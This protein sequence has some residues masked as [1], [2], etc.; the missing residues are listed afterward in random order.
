MRQ[1][2]ACLG[3]CLAKGDVVALSGPLG[4]GKTT[5]VQGLAQGLGVPAERHVSSPTFALVNQ[6]P[7]RIDLV[8]VD[9]Y[10]IASPAELPELGLE[11]AYDQAA[12]A[13]EWA[14]RFPDSLP[15]DVLQFTLEIADSRTRIVHVYGEG[16][17]SRALALALAAKTPFLA[18][19]H[20]YP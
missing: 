14:D 4:A 13:I 7:G 20:E 12:T 10:R 11:E 15:E 3:R 19:G 17:R 9:F 1:L 8:H 5:F 2:G 16:A 18:C 6:H